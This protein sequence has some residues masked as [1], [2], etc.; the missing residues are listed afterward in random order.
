MGK[1]VVAVTVTYN[2]SNTLEKTIK[3]LLNQTEK[4]LKKIIIVDNGSNEIH[5]E[6]L[7]LLENINSKI[8]VVYLNENL[9]GAGGF[10]KG[11]EYAKKKYN[12]EWYWIMDDDAYP[13]KDCLEKMLKYSD[14]L[15][16][17]GCLT[18]AIYGI[19]KNQYQIY[20]HK[21]I[22]KFKI[23]DISVT[24]NYHLLDKVTKIE[25]NAFVGPLFS[26]YAIER[27]G[28]PDGDLFIYGDDTEYTYRISRE[29]NLYLIKESIID[30]QDV[31]SQ[32]NITLP[33]AWWKDYYMYRNKF[34]FV[35]KFE[36]NILKRNLAILFLSY[37]ILKK[38]IGTIIKED[39]K[40]FRKI[41]IK[42]LLKALKDGIYGISGK[43]ID[44]S[45]YVK[46]INEKKINH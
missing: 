26:K 37:L 42:I 16:N 46:Y 21:N 4:S 10:F 28:L 39:Y 29:F 9:G 33:E 36:H 5:L 14:K 3:S 11:M 40:H 35:K 38:C 7:R 12:P 30:H 19:D 6:K 13:R 25:A 17:I 43:T 34:L 22:S 2:R 24:S 18:P 31:L 23:K 45:E 1:V 27:L 44:P 41:R 15:D 32:G 20:H 8:E